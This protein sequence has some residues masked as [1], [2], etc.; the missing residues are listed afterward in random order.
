MIFEENW[1]FVEEWEDWDFQGNWK[2]EKPVIERVVKV[3]RKGLEK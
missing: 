2:D 1:T 3:I